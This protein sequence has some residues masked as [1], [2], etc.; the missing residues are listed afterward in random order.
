M[1]GFFFSVLF[2]FCLIQALQA[3]YFAEEYWHVGRIITNEGDTLNGDINYNLSTNMVQMNDEGIIQT[4]TSRKV[5]YFDFLDT[6]LGRQREFYNLP[7]TEKKS[8]YEVPTFFELLYQG[9]PISL[10]CRET[11]K[12]E[13]V[14][15]LNTFSPTPA[16]TRTYVAYD[17]FLLRIEQK[18][19]NVKAKIDAFSK[20]SQ[21]LE[22]LSDWDE[23]IESYID[24]NKLDLDDKYEVVDIITYY[25]SLKQ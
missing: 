24:E 2:T 16:M 22:L 3:Q 25:N 5:L 20:E 23:I 18:N 7:Y 9:Q 1:K 6:Q 11:L 21:L 10:L 8:N 15:T 14:T 19:G 12:S 4:L 17:Y 13:T